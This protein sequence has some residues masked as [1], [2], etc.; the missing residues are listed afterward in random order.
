[1]KH[2]IL[3]RLNESSKRDLIDS[4]LVFITIGLRFI[5]LQGMILMFLTIWV[6]LP[7]YHLHQGYHHRDI[8]YN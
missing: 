2:Y 7:I 4:I 1:M 8:N 5:R 3:N 6:F